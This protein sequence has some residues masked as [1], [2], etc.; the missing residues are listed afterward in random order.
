MTNF[1]EDLVKELSG[2]NLT[3]TPKIKFV[4]LKLADYTGTIRVYM[5]KPTTLSGYFNCPA[6]VILTVVRAAER[7]RDIH[8]LQ[9]FRLM[10]G[11]L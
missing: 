1:Y 7:I 10:R 11:D 2:V 3:A 9:F 6:D 5:D 8:R 4:E